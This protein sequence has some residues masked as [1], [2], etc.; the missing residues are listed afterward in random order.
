MDFGTIR[1][2]AQYDCVTVGHL[3]YFLCNLGSL[4]NASQDGM[5]ELPSRVANDWGCIGHGFQCQLVY[6][7]CTC[8]PVYAE[9]T[10]ELFDTLAP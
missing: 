1:Y 8:D 9:S 6:P 7:T 4:E 3:Q 10:R 5:W 2:V